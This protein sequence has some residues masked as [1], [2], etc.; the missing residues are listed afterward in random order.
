MRAVMAGVCLVFVLAIF[1]WWLP[2]AVRLLRNIPNLSVGQAV[3]G[4]VIAVVPLVI[5]FGPLLV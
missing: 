1:G 2:K 4:V 5:G 3:G